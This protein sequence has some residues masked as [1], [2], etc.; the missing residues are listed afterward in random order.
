MPPFGGNF[1]SNE[2]DLPM[3]QPLLIMFSAIPPHALAWGGIAVFQ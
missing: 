2:A 3:Y 1:I